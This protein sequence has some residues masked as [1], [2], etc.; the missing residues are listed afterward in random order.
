MRLSLSLFQ[1]FRPTHKNNGATS[2][3]APFGFDTHLIAPQA[4]FPRAHESSRVPRHLRRS[5]AA[6]WS[7]GAEPGRRE[8]RSTL[9]QDRGRINRDGDAS[10]RADYRAGT[11]K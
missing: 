11:A 9:D 5:S 10:S 1:A 7:L 3:V 2:M 8:C 6:A 4:A